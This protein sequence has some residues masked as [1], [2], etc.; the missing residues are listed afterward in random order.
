MWHVF[1]HHTPKFRASPTLG[2]KCMWSSCPWKVL[3]CPLSSVPAGQSAPFSLRFWTLPFCLSLLLI[4]SL[5][6]VNVCVLSFRPYPQ[7]VIF[8][9]CPRV[10]EQFS[11]EGKESISQNMSHPTILWG[12]FWQTFKSANFH[13]GN[14]KSFTLWSAWMNVF[15]SNKF[16]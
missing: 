15:T 16:P 5:W 1:H 2:W 11:R 7:E 12:K 14:V 13:V 4:G 3:S 6:C 10:N 9:E 8:Y